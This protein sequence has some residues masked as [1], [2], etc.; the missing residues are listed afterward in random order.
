MCEL[1]TGVQT[2]ALPIW[3]L[4]RNFAKRVDLSHLFRKGAA[5][6]I[7]K[8]RIFGQCLVK[9]L[10]RFFGENPVEIPG[11]F[12]RIANQ[13]FRPDGNRISVHG[14]RTRHNV[15]IEYV[16]AHWTQTGGTMSTLATLR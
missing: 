13:P 7:G 15:A 8:A 3:E 4:Y 10:G 11:K 5:T 9:A 1:V 16:G 12:R 6:Q 2:C 14:S